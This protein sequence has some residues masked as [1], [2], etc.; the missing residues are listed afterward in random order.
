[1]TTTHQYAGRDFEP[2]EVALLTRLKTMIAEAQQVADEARGC[3]RQFGEAGFAA[4]AAEKPTIIEK[5]FIVC[6]CETLVA[7][8][9]VPTQPANASAEAA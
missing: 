4:E 9:V 6:V 1:M 8:A 7:I 5:R 2:H 3:A